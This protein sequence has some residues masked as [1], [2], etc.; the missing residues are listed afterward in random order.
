MYIQSNLPQISTIRTLTNLVEEMLKSIAGKRKRLDPL[1]IGEAVKV[2]EAAGI[3]VD[4]AEFLRQLAARL[5]PQ[6]SRIA[7]DWTNLG[8]AL[9]IIAGTEFRLRELVTL[10][11]IPEPV[12]SA[13]EQF[14]QLAAGLGVGFG[15]ANRTR[16]ERHRLLIDTLARRPGLYVTEL[17][18]HLRRQLRVEVAYR[19]IWEDTR[20]L[21]LQG[22]LITVG[23]PQGHP[24]YCFPHP[25]NILNRKVY[26]SSFFCVQ[27]TIAEDLTDS[28]F[29]QKRLFDVFRVE[30]RKVHV[31]LVL[32]SRGVRDDLVGTNV[33]SFGR[34]HAFE[35]L[36]SRLRVEPRHRMSELDTVKALCVTKLADGVEN[37]VWY[38]QGALPERSLYSPSM[39]PAIR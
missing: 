29:M 34:L 20:H 28:F 25:A 3:S 22:K 31:L 9:A 7:S 2:V 21:E 13:R 36:R 6:H 18:T 1:L 30:S 24:R 17:Y 16:A 15:G 39:V 11:E 23:G 14:D 19:T 12:D 38:D 27:G 26:Y 32:K 10:A 8:H 4:D 33:K 5:V 37:V 35:Y